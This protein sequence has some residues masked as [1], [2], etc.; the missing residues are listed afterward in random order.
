MEEG[1]FCCFFTPIQ[2]TGTQSTITTNGGILASKWMNMPF[3][4]PTRRVRSSNES[5]YWK[6]CRKAHFR[7]CTVQS[8]S[9]L[10]LLAQGCRLNRKQTWFDHVESLL[11]VLNVKNTHRA[12]HPSKQKTPI[13]L[14]MPPKMYTST[15]CVQPQPVAAAAAAADVAAAYKPLPTTPGI[16]IQIRSNRTIRKYV[17]TGKTEELLAININ[18]APK[19]HGQSIHCCDN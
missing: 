14:A 9:R 15:A 13:R 12:L 1:A 10:Q 19:I 7:A 8:C 6:W 11:I 18:S 4:E 3:T 2:G 16:E 5:F 17:R